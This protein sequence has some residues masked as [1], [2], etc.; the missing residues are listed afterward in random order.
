MVNKDKPISYT[1]F[2]DHLSKSL[3]SVVP[4]P[5]VYGTH[6]FRSGGATKAANSGVGERVF[7][8]HGRWKSVSA[9]DGYVKDN[10]TSR[11][12][13]SKSLGLKLR[14]SIFQA[15]SLSS[16]RLLIVLWCSAKTRKINLMVHYVLCLLRSEAEI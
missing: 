11:I 14:A 5:S 6:S 8:R 7:Q 10:I 2:R 12:S 4:D 3:R 16:I 13:V 1:T 9:K 15:L